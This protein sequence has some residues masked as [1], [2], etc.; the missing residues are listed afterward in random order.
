M[1]PSLISRA[2][3]ALSTGTQHTTG[4]FHG[5]TID[6]LGEQ[7]RRDEL[8]AVDLATAALA[9]VDALD[10]ELNAVVTLDRDGALRAAEK[11]D[12]ELSDGLDR[13][14]LHGIPVAVKD[15]IDVAGLR[16]TMGSAHFADHVS[17]SDAECV[18]R[19]REAGAV[20]IGKTTTHEFAFGPTGDRAHNG[21][22]RNPHDRGRMT[23]GSSGGS[24]AAVAAGMVPLALGTDTGGSVRIP[25]SLCGVAGFKPA[26]GTIPTDGV[27][28]LSQ[29]LDHVGVLA[30]TTADCRLAYRVL[31]GL[32]PMSSRERGSEV[33][34]GWIPPDLL[35]L[36]DPRVTGVARTALDVDGIDVREVR[37]SGLEGMLR[38]FGAIQFSEAHAV[39][40]ERIADAPQ[41]FTDDVLAILRLAGETAGWQYVRALGERDDWRAEVAGLLDE[42]EL[43]AMPTTCVT[44]PEIDQREI[45]VNGTAT[46]VRGPLIGLT[47]PWNLAG[48]PAISVPAGT[49]DGLPVGLQ[50][51][52]RPGQEDR[53]FA[54]AARLSR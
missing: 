33:S 41:L 21:P 50:L 28:P 49:V 32:R 25:A 13:G 35:H 20:I 45:E 27:F 38:A 5:R 4:F 29:T 2:G 53:L 3:G 46:P 39:H 30:G 8:R 42:V 40:A 6:E 52:G 34:L 31:A 47:R 11:A 19:L 37:P 44:A 26:H 1:S 48:A 7:L 9:A 22:S 10:G 16:T 54:V 24:G 18:R 36:T 15:I 51:V 12:A 43:L 23:G 14:A 17:T